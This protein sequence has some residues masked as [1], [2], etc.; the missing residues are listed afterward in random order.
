[1]AIHHAA[2]RHVVP[3]R[4]PAPAA[5][6]P[7]APLDTTPR[8][9]DFAGLMFS[10]T[11]SENAPELDT[12]FAAGAMLG[13]AP[14]V[15]EKTR[16][17]DLQLQYGGTEHTQADAGD[18]VTWLCFTWHPSSSSGPATVWFMS[19]HEMADIGNTLSMVVLEKIDASRLDGCA[20]APAAL[21]VP[22]FALP[23]PGAS[24]TDIKAKL[25]NSPPDRQSDSVY[26][27]STRALNDGSGMSVY[28]SLGYTLDRS[29]STTG[30]ALSQVTTD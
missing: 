30:I 7:A 26:Y 14:L 25:G 9:T 19:T 21:V 3:H 6:V 18:G 13:S 12:D 17:D 4:P 2:K 11:A 5:P 16:L 10:G 28:Q 20:E 27:D 22:T 15:F 23:A 29:G 8:L 24:L 1:V